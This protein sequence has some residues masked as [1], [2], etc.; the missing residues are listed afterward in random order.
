MWHASA[1]IE[2]I[3]KYIPDTYKRL[4]LI[5]ET[6]G[7]EKFLETVLEQYPEMDNITIEYGVVENDAQVAVIPIDLD[8][9]DVGS[10]SSLKDALVDDVKGH[11][12]KG[13]HVDF[14]SENLLVYGSKKLITTVGLKDLV[15]VDTEDAILICDRHQSKMISDVVKKLESSGKISLL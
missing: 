15:I 12:V 2:K 6:V 14:G 10:W 7:K 8:W 5:K 11:F 13:E 9:S 3:Q 4:M 1:I